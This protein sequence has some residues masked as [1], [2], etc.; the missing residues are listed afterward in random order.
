MRFQ[1]EK[2][3]TITFSLWLV[4][5][6]GLEINAELTLESV[7]EKVNHLEVEVATLKVNI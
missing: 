1:S 4:M 3:G 2:M 7:Y 5:L 6:K